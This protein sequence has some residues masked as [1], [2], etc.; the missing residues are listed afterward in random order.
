MSNLIINILVGIITGTISGYLVSVYFERKHGKQKIVEDIR[1]IINSLPHFRSLI[2]LR[3][4]HDEVYYNILGLTNN[5]TDVLK[6]IKS[7][8]E[9]R[10]HKDGIKDIEYVLENLKNI[11]K[12]V[13]N[14]ISDYYEIANQDIKGI[15]VSLYRLKSSYKVKKRIEGVCFGRFNGISNM[16]YL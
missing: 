11:L 2:L 8:C 1:T 9:A 16:I 5:W 7:N 4:E 13:R 12:I 14:P 10:G 3:K 6:E 15:L